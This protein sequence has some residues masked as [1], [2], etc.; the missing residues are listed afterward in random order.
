[1]II[2]LSVA[3]SNGMTVFSG[4]PEVV[5][6]KYVSGTGSTIESLSLGSHSGTHIDT[7]AHF[8]PDAGTTSQLKLERLISETYILNF[9]SINSSIKIGKKELEKY[10]DFIKPGNSVFLNTGF[11]HSKSSETFNSDFPVL[12]IDGAEYL[13]KN[14]ISVIGTE[15]PSI[16]ASTIEG[17]SVHKLLLENDIII[18]EGLV[19]LKHV[20]NQPVKT[21]A[22]PLN[23]N[24]CS[25]APCRV[26]A[27]ED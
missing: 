2:D 13:V 11:N 14:K 1:M 21:I 10:S 4:H 15:S 26:I 16:G 22:L 8:L 27:L 18:I 6:K 3:I 12:S 25:G 7:P 20:N 23:L 19:N 5:I 9:S 17:I 24:S